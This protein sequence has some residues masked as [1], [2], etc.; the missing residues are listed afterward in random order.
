M[1]NKRPIIIDTDP[2]IDDAVAIAAAVFSNSVDVKLISTVAGNVSIDYTTNNALKLVEFFGKDIPVAQ[3]SC[4]PLT[5]EVEH[6]SNIHGETGMAGYDFPEPTRTIIAK[7][8]VDA[9]RDVI[10][11]S[12]EKVT[13]VPIGPLTNIALLLTTYPEVKENI[14]EIVLMGGSSG[15]GNHTPAAEFNIYVDPEAAK[16]VFGSKVKIVVC[17]L[18]VTSVATLDLETINKLK[19]MNKVGDMFYSMFNHYRGGSVSKGGLKMHDLTTIAYLDKPELF[20]KVETFVDVETA[21][22]YTSGFM[23][24]DFKGT[25]N[26]PNNATFCTEINVEEF[27]EWMLNIFKNINI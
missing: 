16:I 26:K 13:L 10:L 12:K 15:R 20:E 1:N 25:Y 27:R 7:N 11:N 4:K 6:C 17:S 14:E 5:R 22:E 23:V 2:G 24:V 21:G 19:V 8:S 18:D 3:G 9:M